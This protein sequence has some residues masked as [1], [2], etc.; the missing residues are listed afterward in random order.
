MDTTPDEDRSTV[1]LNKNRL[2]LTIPHTN[3][4]A[5]CRCTH[6]NAAQQIKSHFSSEEYD[7]Y[8]SCYATWSEAYR[9]RIVQMPD[10]PA[11]RLFDPLDPE[12][13][14]KTDKRDVLARNWTKEWVKFDK[15]P[16]KKRTIR[17]PVFVQKTFE[18]KCAPPKHKT[19]QPAKGLLKPPTYQV[20]EHQST[21]D[22]PRK[23]N[24]KKSQKILSRKLP[25]L[26]VPSNL[27][28]TLT[29]K[30][31]LLSWHL[32]LGHLPFGVITNMA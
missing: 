29:P 5:K 10:A 28:A 32:R 15:S 11:L 24:E 2:R 26:Q 25:T 27:P 7:C 31:E 23:R 17:F 30:Q 16:T 1:F 4:L 9:G 18:H 20:R 3:G 6:P 14:P 12:N 8:N 13:L 22:V 21:P 19:E